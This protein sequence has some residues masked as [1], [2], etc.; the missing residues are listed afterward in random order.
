[1]II[2]IML[3]NGPLSIISHLLYFLL[4]STAGSQRHKDSLGITRWSSASRLA[5]EGAP[6]SHSSAEDF[7]LR[8]A[9]EESSMRRAELIQRL[10][11]ARDHLDAQT[12]L[13][14]TKGFQLQQS[15]S[16][17]N[18]LD[19]KHKV[20]VYLSHWFNICGIWIL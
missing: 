12:D 8:A 4:I 10:R 6:R 18:L 3:V 20:W 14:K 5:P 19:I 17:S 13:L 7:E 16:L 2:A 15:K 11:E 1:M 9:L